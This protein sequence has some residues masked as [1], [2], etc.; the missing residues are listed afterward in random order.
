MW[1]YYDQVHYKLIYFLFHYPKESY[2]RLKLLVS[3]NSIK[4]EKNRNIISVLYEKMNES[5][6]VD[7]IL[8]WFDDNEIVNYITGIL[9][10]D[11]ELTDIEKGIG[12]IENA[13]KK[14]S[15]VKRRDEIINKLND[16][17]ISKEESLELGKELND[18]IINLAKIK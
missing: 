4:S 18:I 15:L 10:Y 13:Y 9:A 7:N 17:N 3:I 1:L 16:K 6:N 8:D 14:D 5:E 11:F 12:G 2:N